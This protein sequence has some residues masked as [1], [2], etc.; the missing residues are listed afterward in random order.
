M[1]NYF[2]PGEFDCWLTGERHQQ[3][4]V[5]KYVR[6]HH[7]KPKMPA[8]QV[9]TYCRDQSWQAYIIEPAIKKRVRVVRNIQW[10]LK[11]NRK[12]FDNS[13]ARLKGVHRWRPFDKWEDEVIMNAKPVK[14]A[15]LLLNRSP[16]SVFSR[17][18]YLKKLAAGAN[19]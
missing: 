9:I 14:A 1:S 13:M 19:A 16:H 11:T 4:P 17:R 5:E 3:E 15:C 10:D 18:Y 12:E 6:V 2:N 8:K 7:P